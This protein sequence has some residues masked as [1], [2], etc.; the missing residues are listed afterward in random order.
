MKFLRVS[1]V[2]LASLVILSLSV[3]VLYTQVVKPIEI[4]VLISKGCSDYRQIANKA[5]PTA[6]QVD[7]MSHY[8]GKLARLEPKFLQ[9]ATAVDGFWYLNN[10]QSHSENLNPQFV[11]DTFIL[12]SF[13]AR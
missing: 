8:F 13:C 1:T 4:R 2:A 5:K 11:R 10:G 12:Y 9:V 7:S 6:Q 3:S